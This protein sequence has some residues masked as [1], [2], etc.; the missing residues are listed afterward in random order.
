MTDNNQPP[1]KH[2]S[3]PE[4]AL[5]AASNV[6][7]SFDKGILPAV[8]DAAIKKQGLNVETKTQV[9]GT[10]SE[11]LQSD[12]ITVDGPE[13]WFDIRVALSPFDIP[14]RKHEADVIQEE[15]LELA[16]Q[17]QTK[18][19]EGKF[20]KARVVLDGTTS[21]DIELDEE[22]AKL[23]GAKDVI[24]TITT[25]QDVTDIVPSA[26]EVEVDQ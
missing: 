17:T 18:F 2:E 5:D 7:F 24:L 9:T 10:L 4:R 11:I 6:F 12:S 25:R 22:A 13:P 14:T 15:S 16:T 3:K 8:T 26:M 1:A 21:E 20:G 19:L 23:V